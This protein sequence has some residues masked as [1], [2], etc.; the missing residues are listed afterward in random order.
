MT[1]SVTI[2]TP[3]GHRLS[4]RLERPAGTARA[5]AL[6]AHCFTCGKDQ[7]GAVKVSRA[8]AARG[9]ATL[10]FDLTGIGASDGDF[11]ET[12]F[13]ANVEDIVAAA[14]WMRTRHQA[15]NLL[16]GHSL[17]GAAI[18][19]A[20]AQIPDVSAIVTIGAPADAA[21]VLHQFEDAL[22][23]IEQAGEAPVTLGG[24]RFVVR[25]GFVEDIRAQSLKAHLRNLRKP[26]LILHAPTD[27]TVG[28]EN[29]TALFSAARHPKSFISLD[30][31]NH[32]LSGPGE[33]DA[34]AAAIA[35]WAD[36]YLPEAEV[37][38][39]SDAPAPGGVRVE[40][41]GGGTFE[42]RILTGRHALL[43]DEPEDVGGGD[44]GPGPYDLLAAA[45]GS[46]TSM[47][48]RMYAARKNWPLK[49]VSV[50]VRHARIHAADCA[51]CETKEGKV[52][53]LL[54]SLRL[55]GPLDAEQ[56]ARLLEIAHKCPVH[57]TLKS[58]VIISAGL[59]N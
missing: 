29:A 21:H 27:D 41:T 1:E 23:E 38:N 25:R 30:G 51:D 36:R 22:P 43:A 45:L 20:A 44:S 52:D 47:T 10:R 4:G 18:L 3:T 49:R 16:I 33:A 14:D 28:I 7:T 19:A 46:C 56:R 55:D 39:S 17:G 48:V 50:E 35:G 53:Q 9:I 57:R 26:L 12:S 31:S 13:S 2:D 40:E 32:F 37:M 42:N 24:R 6:F 34:A 11:A 58:E 54:V 59:E 5:Y 8:L 15:P